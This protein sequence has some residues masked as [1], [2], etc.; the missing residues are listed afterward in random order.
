MRNLKEAIL[1]F[2]TGENR[3]RS[4]T[5]TSVEA[6]YLIGKG[7]ENEITEA[8]KELIKEEKLIETK[9]GNYIAPSEYDLKIGKVK[10]VPY[11]ALIECNGDTFFMSKEHAEKKAGGLIDGD[12]V[13]FSPRKTMNDKFKV[14]NTSYICIEE[15]GFNRRKGCWYC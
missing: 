7:M 4:D 2:V 3:Y 6:L 9:K 14:P 11:G 13:Y 15:N 10:I 1:E 5:L 12:E 8:L